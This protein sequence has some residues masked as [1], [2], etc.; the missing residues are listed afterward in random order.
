MGVTTTPATGARGAVRVGN[1]VSYGVLVQPTH[2]IDFTSETLSAEETTLE[3]EAIRDDRGRHQIL[4]GQLDVQGD[5]AFEQSASGFAILYRAALGDYIQAPKSDGGIHA[6]LAKAGSVAITAAA[7]GQDGFALIF[8]EDHSGGFDPLAGHFSVV[9]R[10]GLNTLGYD[11]NTGAGYAYDSYTPS[12]RSYVTAV[13]PAAADY[14]G[15]TGTATSVV[16][17]DVT[18]EHGASVAPRFNPAGGVVKLGP[19][20]LEYRYFEYNEAGRKLFLSE[21][22][23]TA[24][25]APVVNDYVLGLSGLTNSTATGD[26][27]AASGLGVGN[28]IYQWDGTYDGVITHHIERGRRLPVG[29][30]VEVD[31]DAAIFK[32]SGMKVDTMTLNFE[33]NSIVT[34]SFTFIGRE[35]RSVVSLQA[36]VIPGAT[37]II[38]DR[39][40]A[41]PTPDP[42]VGAVLTIGEETD[43]RYFTKVRNPDDTWTLG[44]ILA[45][46]NVVESIHRFHEKGENVDSRSS[47]AAAT[48]YEGDNT[49]LSAFEI[50]V[51]MDGYFEEVM[52]GSITLANNL[53]TDKY[54]LGSRFRLATIEGRAEV[55]GSLTMEF[56][57][58]K[59]YNKFL[60]GNFFSL[61]FK[62]VS[63]ADDS[64]IGNT[65]VPSQAYYFMPKCRFSGTTPQ[66]GGPEIIQHDMPF[67]A[68]V[69][70]EL[71]TTDLIV[72]LVNDNEHDALAA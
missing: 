58:G 56:D 24:N 48:I 35:E 6:R 57:D 36:D 69:D 63:E 30:T 38:V 28:W 21:D 52:A 60:K 41:F 71:K 46:L 8:A 7:G 10:D 13:D 42:A 19:N 23:V 45:D 34:G 33:A 15:A 67:T 3:S 61:E 18:D 50:L 65:G 66:I 31:R 51:Y 32:Y 37:S 26:F 72:I 1:E 11:D 22:D 49:P 47:T 55:D 64:E 43:I 27:A 29:L 12:S 68:V 9:Y 4:R 2:L 53:A 16:V 40:D 14:T 62:C 20:R 44:G 39:A 54:A 17:A 25:G 59:H 5:I 70:D